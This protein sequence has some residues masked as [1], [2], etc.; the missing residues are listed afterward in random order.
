MLK[1]A[2][3]EDSLQQMGHSRGDSRWVVEDGQVHLK[4]VLLPGWG[5]YLVE[6][7]Q[8]SALA[9]PEMAVPMAVE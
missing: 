8:N 3:G 1:V 2:L 9:I 6:E 4:L 7:E 5:N